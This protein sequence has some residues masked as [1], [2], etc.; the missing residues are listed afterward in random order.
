MNEIRLYAF[1]VGWCTEDKS[2]LTCRR[3]VGQ[4]VRFPVPCFLITHP[5]GNVLIDTGYHKDIEIDPVKRF[6]QAR[7]DA[8][9]ILI[10]KNVLAW[11]DELG[12]KPDDIR[13]VINTH[14]HFDHCGL[15]QYFPNST[16]LVQKDELRT[17]FW[18]EIFQRGAYSRDDF[19]HKLHYE[20]IED[21]YD[22]YGDGVITTLKTPGHTQGHQS[23]IVKLP[24]E[25]TFVLTG[26]SAYLKENIDD[27]VAPGSNYSMIDAVNSLRKMRY[28][29]D[30]MGYNVIPGHDPEYWPT[31]RKAPEYYS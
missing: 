30:V 5:K 1:E 16:F 3:G 21:S 8:Q 7:A 31:I 4:K 12:Y 9:D 26:D 24:K 2:T 13:Y 27:L 18:P 15:N 23:V 25:G 14:L 29:R 11:L 20:E 17:A 22:V 10:E 19:D 28:L 6:G